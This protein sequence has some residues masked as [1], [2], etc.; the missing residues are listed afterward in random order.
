MKLLNS[1]ES[2]E[3]FMIYN[4]IF[5]GGYCKCSIHLIKK[6]RGQALT[7]SL[8]ESPILMR[9][10]SRWFDTSKTGGVNYGN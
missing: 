5:G 9:G 2:E 3:W 8:S 4:R 6:E 10:G 1:N 7:C